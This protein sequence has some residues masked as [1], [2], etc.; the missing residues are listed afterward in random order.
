MYI[1]LSSAK[2]LKRQNQSQ[3]ISNKDKY[4]NRE[5]KLS[6]FEVI[7][8]QRQFH[9]ES[10]YKSYLESGREQEFD[11]LFD[12]AVVEAKSGF[13]GRLS[14]VHSRQGSLFKGTACGKVTDRWNQIGTFQKGTKETCTACNMR[15][16]KGIQIMAN[17]GLQA[18]GIAIFRN[19]AEL[20]SKRKFEHGCDT[21]L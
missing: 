20:L 11:R 5:A 4:I 13:D 7:I 17:A 3:K 8:C 1:Y 6:H 19:A 10:T 21:Q 14:D 9:N 18:K 12:K 16:A 15:R 2:N